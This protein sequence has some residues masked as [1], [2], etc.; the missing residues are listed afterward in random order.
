MIRAKEGVRDEEEDSNGKEIRL[1][2][3]KEMG[4]KMGMGRKVQ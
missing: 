1:N 3:E 4:R 2:R